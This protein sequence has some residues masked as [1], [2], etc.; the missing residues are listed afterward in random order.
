M[1]KRQFQACFLS[2]AC[3]ASVLGLTVHDPASV[4]SGT[5]VY[6]IMRELRTRTNPDMYIT[7]LL[8]G[9]SSVLTSCYF[10]L[11]N[12]VLGEVP[13]GT[14]EAVDCRPKKKGKRGKKTSC[15]AVSDRSESSDAPVVDGNEENYVVNCDID[16]RF[17][18][19][20]SLKTDHDGHII[21]TVLFYCFILTLHNLCC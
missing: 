18:V 5:V 8:G 6:N 15:R 21:L 4:L 7:E 3:I 19:F 13:E 10:Q 11:V 2:A 1:Y 9:S 17:S 20:H 14:L 16:N 12:A